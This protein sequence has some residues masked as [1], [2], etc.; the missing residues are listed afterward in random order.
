[1]SNST[2]ASPEFDAG[3][4]AGLVD[5][6]G[7]IFVS[8]NKDNDRTVPRMRIFGTSKPVVDGASRIM[9]V[10]THPRRD[11]GEL[12]GW[13]A[14]AQGRKAVEAMKEILPL[15]TDPSKKCR[16][17]T[18]TRLFANT[19]SI[20]GKHPSSEIFA[21]CPPPTR[22]RLQRIPN[23]PIQLHVDRS[24]LTSSR[25]SAQTITSLP[26]EK[27]STLRK[28]WLSGMVDGEGYVHIRY[29]GDRNSMYPRLRILV[30]NRE[31]I[32]PVASLMN[33]NPYAR[34]SHGEQD[35]WYASVSHL[36]ALRILRLIGPHLLD[37]S[38]KCRAQKIIERFGE[39][40]TIHSRLQT[41]DFFRDCPPPSRIR[42]S[43]RVISGKL[44][45][46]F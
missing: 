35:G 37:P 44:E 19:P 17:L 30:K 18:A 33:V 27:M 16:A 15:L 31:I 24:A 14:L 42:K 11:H 32:E 3:Y 39:I 2:A 6:E 36:K 38:K 5:G 34:R 43:G 9:R 41:S 13:D 10:N 1:M 45:G 25:G 40:G 26:L 4:L 46:L 23:S 7:C 12:K 21:S 28:G 22:L 20:R 29:R 8:Y